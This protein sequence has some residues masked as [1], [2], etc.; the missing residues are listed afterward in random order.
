MYKKIII[1]TV[2]VTALVYACKKSEPFDTVT[3]EDLADR[4]CNDP[5]AINYNI[6]FPGTPDNSIC[7]YPTD[8][9]TD[10]YELEDS[11]FNA[12][13]ELDTVYNYTVRFLRISQTRVFLTGYCPG[14][15]SLELTADR[16]YKASVDSTLLLPDSTLLPGQ[17]FCRQLDTISGS[18]IKYPDD[19]NKIRITFTIASDTGINLHYGTGIKK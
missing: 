2:L 19:S 6:G 8:V 12:D 9:F 3:Q 16:Y 15:D 13:V 18:I 7:I 11:V 5:I 10:T 4:Y 1:F 14:G 17:V